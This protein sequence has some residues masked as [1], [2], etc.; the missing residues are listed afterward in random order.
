MT[1][2]SGPAGP[3]PAVYVISGN[4]SHYSF[5]VVTQR[6]APPYRLYTGS[7][8]RKSCQT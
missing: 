2:Y 3:C 1:G 4:T 7:G 5:I 8:P 6:P